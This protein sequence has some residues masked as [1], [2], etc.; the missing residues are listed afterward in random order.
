MDFSHSVAVIELDKHE[1]LLID[2]KILLLLQNFNNNDNAG[3]AISMASLNL[4]T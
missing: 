4:D 3:G 2:K 1:P